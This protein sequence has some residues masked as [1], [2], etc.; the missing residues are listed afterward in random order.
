MSTKLKIILGTLLIVAAFLV[1][2]VGSSFYKSAKTAA[3]ISQTIVTPAPEENFLTKDSDGDGISDRDEIIYGL[4][5]YN[6]D[7]DGDGYLDGEEVAS[8]YDPSDPFSN[9]KSGKTGISLVSPTANLTDRLLNLTIA[10]IINNSGELDPTQ[11]NEK[12][13][14]DILEAVNNEGA[15]SV[16][17]PPPSD[18]DM[19]IINDNSKE[20]VEKYIKSI[21]FIVEGGVFSSEGINEI[22]T[23]NSTY[24]L[25]YENTYYSL[26]VIEVPSSWKEIH[27]TTILTFAQLANSFKIMR[28]LE[29]DPMRASF[30]LNQVQSSFLSLAN[31]LNSI[32]QLAIKQN[33]PLDSVL[34]M[35]Q[36]ANGFLQ[37]P[38]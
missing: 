36:S 3:L 18:S 16:Y 23:P 10:S 13:Y 5:A 29:E 4:D 21:S 30:A 25:Y 27:R 2:R 1:I 28:N 6:K 8:G 19:K 14:A 11:V 9:S 24:Y 20:A 37:S 35:L 15:L 17:L 38:Q 22:A 33:V 32:T 34:Q 31:I 26:K 7:T 12:Q